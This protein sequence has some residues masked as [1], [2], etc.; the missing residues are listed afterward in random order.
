MSTSSDG[1]RRRPPSRARTPWSRPQAGYEEAGFKAK[2]FPYAGGSLY[3]VWT[4]PDNK[5][6]KKLNLRG[7]AWCQ[8]WPSAATFLPPLFQTGEVYN[9]GEFSEKAIDDEM[10]ADP[11]AADRG[12]GRTPGVSSSKTLNQEYFP[13]ST[14]G[15]TTTCQVYGGAIGNYTYDTVQGYPNLRD[16]YVTQ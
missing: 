13:T 3:D 9:T 10:A 6:N 2:P 15:T 12:A 16:V 4:D 5:I 1:L 14:P 7:T 8:D 11:D